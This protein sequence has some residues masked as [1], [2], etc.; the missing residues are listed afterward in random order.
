VKSINA[1]SEEIMSPHLLCVITSMVFVALGCS[2]SEFIGQGS[3]SATGQKSQFGKNLNPENQP[4]ENDSDSAE[5]SSKGATFSP[6]TD[7]LKYDSDDNGSLG[8][9]QG[10]DDYTP[11]ER[12]T[13][14]WFAVSG[15]AI[16]S[17]LT[18]NATSYIR[19]VHTDYGGIFPRT[20]SGN[21]LGWGE[22][23]DNVGG[24]VL[25]P[26][27][28]AYVYGEGG[29]E[30]DLAVDRSFDG[31]VVAPGLEVEIRD[32]SGNVIIK[33]EGPLIAASEAWIPQLRP[34]TDAIKANTANPQWMLDFVDGLTTVPTYPLRGGRWVKVSVISGSKCDN[35]SP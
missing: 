24:I 19:Q 7:V 29:E 30:I 1:N 3:G 18:A 31:I 33:R 16:G 22:S 13:N 25:A 17:K 23:F 34:F 15:V 28:E 35:S 4:N 5:S 6:G 20:K 2:D 27:D 14:C 9:G 12:R 10:R 26:R 11:E 8:R 32:A 21:P